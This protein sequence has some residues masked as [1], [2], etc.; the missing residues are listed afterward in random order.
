M[1]GMIRLFLLCFI[2]LAAPG[3]GF[4]AK[5]NGERIEDKELT[6]FLAQPGTGTAL[7][8]AILFH[9]ALQ[10]ARKQGLDKEP[11]VKQALEK[12]LY[13]AYVE[14]LLAQSA[15]EVAPSTAELTAAYTKNPL[16][17]VRHL[18]LLARDEYERKR[19]EKTLTVII[20]ELKK[21][22]PF[23]DLILRY[24]QDESAKMGGDL[25]MMSQD[26]LPP[27]YSD[28]L[29]R[30]KKGEVSSPVFSNGAFHLVQL[31]DRK[32]FSDAPASYHTQLEAQIQKEREI[33]LITKRL[34]HL[35]D[36]AKVEFPSKRGTP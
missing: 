7:E 36:Q 3:Q 12:V 26:R 15:G 1:A 2:A 6:P 34:E 11:Q 16:V 32:S 22:T 13:Q 19:A 14:R 29:P 20:S 21:G 17:R 35:R 25:D 5:V 4:V 30:L 28:S 9:I 27:F 8:R 33:A 31:L 23:R 10:D 24:S 18:V